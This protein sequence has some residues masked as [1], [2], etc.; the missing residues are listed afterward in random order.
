MALRAAKFIVDPKYCEREIYKRMKEAYD[1]RSAIVH[2]RRTTDSKLPDINKLE[3][4]VRL[5]LRKALS[6][7]DPKRLKEPQYWE[8]LILSGSNPP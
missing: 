1:A 8:S 5:G 2:G 6:F 3:D 4:L 7:D